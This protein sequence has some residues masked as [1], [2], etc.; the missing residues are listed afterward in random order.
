MFSIDGIRWPWPCDITREAEVKASDISGLM[1]D[2][3]YFNDVL[4]TYMRYDVTVAAPPGSGEEYA[5]LYETLTQPVDGHSFVMPYN[6]GEIELT[7]R[8]ASVSDVYVRRS[9]GALWKGLKFSVVGNHPSREMRLD[10]VIAL[11]RGPM[12]DVSNPQEGDSY[13]FSDGVWRRSAVFADGDERE[14]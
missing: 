5:L 3:R 10:E 9:G 7:G 13:T 2:R 12:P 4:G 1:L 6:R 11:G 14:Y 8:V